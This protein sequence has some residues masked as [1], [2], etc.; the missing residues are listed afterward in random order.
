M[1]L[2]SVLSVGDGTVTFGLPSENGFGYSVSASTGIGLTKR[3]D[4][5]SSWNF[6]LHCLES[7]SDEWKTSADKTGD[8]FP[9]ARGAADIMLDTLENTVVINDGSIRCVKRNSYD[10]IT[11]RRAVSEKKKPLTA[12]IVPDTDDIRL[13][14]NLVYNRVRLNPVRID[15]AVKDIVLEEA[16][17]YFSG[18]QTLDRTAE[19]ISDRVKTRL[20][21]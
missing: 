16:S 7:Q 9:A 14:K 10:D 4:S 8:R 3:G 20:S 21:E 18:A 1:A 2:R 5:D 15:G 13:M 6:V 12:R 11:M 19:I 17:A